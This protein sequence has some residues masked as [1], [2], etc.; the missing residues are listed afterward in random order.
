MPFRALPFDFVSSNLHI[1]YL[2]PYTWTYFGHFWNLSP[3]DDSRTIWVPFRK[4]NLS[5]NMVITEMPQNNPKI[6]FWE[7]WVI[8][9]CDL[10]IDCIMFEPSYVVLI[11]MNI[12]HSQAIDFLTLTYYIEYI[13]YTIS[14]HYRAIFV[15]FY[16][17]YCFTVSYHLSCFA[18]YGVGKFTPWSFAPYNRTWM[19]IILRISSS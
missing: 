19:E 6:C 1:M 12:I 16:C 3:S 17:F 8:L 10:K 9:V 4:S 13:T 2:R 7:I 15:L 5:E 18:W 11:F 14:G